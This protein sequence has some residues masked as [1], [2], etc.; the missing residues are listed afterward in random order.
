MGRAAKA[1]LGL[2]G[3]GMMLAVGAASAGAEGSAPGPNVTVAQAQEAVQRA[4][5]SVLVPS[6]P[7]SVEG[8]AVQPGISD[9]GEELA[10]TGS[11]TG[12]TVSK[13]TPGEF[14]VDTVAGELAL[15]PVGVSPAASAPTVVNGTAALFA[16]SWVA[17]D[18]IVRPSAL[19]AISL[20]QLRSLQAPTSFSWD[21][22]L[23]VGERLQQLPD[24]SVAVVSA[25]PGLA[26]GGAGGASVPESSTEASSQPESE[27]AG[28][29]E[30]APEGG[31]SEPEPDRS[32]EEA[33]LASLP[34][35]QTSTPP[36]QQ[37]TPGEL[38]PQETQAQYATAMGAAAAA[39][40]QTGGRTLMVIEP[41]QVTD[42]HGNR[43]TG[44][45]SVFGNTL[46]MT[47]APSA[48]TAFPVIAATAVDASS[49]NATSNRAVQ[50]SSYG[51]SDQ[52]PA[53]FGASFDPKLLFG[54]L[55]VRTA[56][57]I[58][59]YDAAFPSTEKREAKE[60]TEG[61]LEHT[62][63][64]RLSEFLHNVGEV[65]NESHEPLLEPYVTLWSKGCAQ[66]TVCVA[67]PIKRYRKALGILIAR[68]MKGNSGAGLP[69]VKM[70]GAWNE[71][72]GGKTPFHS[73]K[74]VE[75]WQVAQSVSQHLHCGCKVVAG[76]FENATE[77]KP[78]IER[79]KNVMVRRHLKPRVWG[80]HDYKDLAGVTEPL[81]SYPN[82]A[83]EGFA[84]I[85]KTLLGKPRIWLSEQ[86]VELE[87]EA[88]PTRLK[89]NPELQRLAAEDF[90]RLSSVERVELVDYY[91]YHSPAPTTE[92]PHP[93]KEPVFDSAL[94]DEK[95]NPRPAYCV[96]AY[97]S[98][99]CPKP[100]TVITGP[101][102]P[103]TKNCLGEG[104]TLELTGET[105]PNGLS[106]TYYFEYAEKEGEGFPFKTPTQS[107][108]SGTTPIKVNSTVSVKD[109]ALL[110]WEIVYRLVGVNTA[111]TSF[112][113]TR[114][115]FESI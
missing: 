36:A 23:G 55:Q 45:L 80:L 67:P 98:H 105:N 51:F 4:A 65:T 39:E 16:N 102:H 101:V 106:T 17:T 109:P 20:L 71:P 68:Y 47:V 77:H 96:L 58:V 26:L 73:A 115:E 107:A 31:P 13:D 79:Y 54:P 62:E 86:G 59:N 19:G 69:A 112:G 10:S 83:A 27:R 61:K 18:T 94:L 99:E 38:R 1:M 114:L 87:S 14:A 82:S 74:A 42:A 88:G 90:L 49:S 46:T 104:N 7:A 111:G 85:T 21:V 110:C 43:V 72:D 32:A 70:W 29:P 44:S 28:E 60:K 3:V 5:P 91:M 30:D 2:W 48:T 97:E 57:L 75:L 93:E 52:R 35:A 81:S 92:H 78:Y 24:G 11:L 76:E 6:L 108:G 9:S 100:P 15:A 22:G 41:P 50:P 84:K 34:A 66:H 113:E 95:G 103:L 89:G 64:E 56:R 8:Q 53:T 25:R 63:N 12:S 40:T 37:T 33:P